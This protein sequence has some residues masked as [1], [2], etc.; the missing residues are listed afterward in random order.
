MKILIQGCEEEKEEVEEIGGEGAQCRTTAERASVTH[1]STYPHPLL[2]WK[3]L[4][5]L[6]DSLT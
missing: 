6:M 1:H 4:M 3:T 5:G 2:F